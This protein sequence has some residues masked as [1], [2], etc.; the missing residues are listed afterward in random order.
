MTEGI[1]HTGHSVA[2]FLQFGTAGLRGNS[3]DPTQSIETA[4][5]ERPDIAGS[6]F[7]IDPGFDDGTPNNGEDENSGNGN[8]NGNREGDNSQ[9]L[10]GLVEGRT[11]T[12][13]QKIG[14]DAGEGGENAS[15]GDTASGL[16]V[17]GGESGEEAGEDGLASPANGQESSGDGEE[18]PSGLTDEEEKTVAELKK[19]DAET[20]RHEAAHAAVG[21]QYAGSPSYTYQ[22]GPDGRQYAVGGEVSIDTSPIKGD[23]DATIQKMQQ[24]RAAALAPA[25]PSAQDQKVAAAA[26]ATASAARA[27]KAAEASEERRAEATGENDET[28]ETEGEQQNT[29][30]GVSETVG[31]PETADASANGENGDNQR[32]GAAIQGGDSNQGNADRD[33]AAVVSNTAQVNPQPSATEPEGS[34][35][36]SIA[37]ADN[38][39]S[40]EPENSG[41]SNDLGAIEPVS[42]DIIGE[43]NDEDDD[44]LEVAG[45]SEQTRSPSPR[46]SPYNLGPANSNLAPGSAGALPQ[47]ISITV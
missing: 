29:A 1:G 33:G 31:T 15:E 11:L 20:R 28:G 21:G 7:I 40:D 45:P 9:G 3:N 34:G 37:P 6:Q 27:E 16:A 2:S 44:G 47:I 32:S 19:I 18:N 38:S 39:G 35:P 22:S 25:E 36:F 14:A 30:E 4:D 5:T 43:S 24:V 13:A 8:F 12:I 42:F 10:G 17:E 46:T 26:Q 23:P 41:S